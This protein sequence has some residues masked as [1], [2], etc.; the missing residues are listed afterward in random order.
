FSGSGPAHGLI[1]SRFDSARWL[2]SKGVTKLARAKCD[3]LRSRTPRGKRMRAEGK[4]SGR[5]PEFSFFRLHLKVPL[6]EQPRQ[7][8]AKPFR[9]VQLPHG[10]PILLRA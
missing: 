9:W 10:T 8:S 4:A 7:R 3:S 2:K 5:I 1:R 6:A